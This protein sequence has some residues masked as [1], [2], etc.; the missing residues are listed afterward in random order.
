MRR[1]YRERGVLFG[2]ERSL[3]GVSCR[4]VQSEGERPVI[5]F[6]NSGIVHRIGGNRIYVTLARAL[7]D[8]GFGSL[9]FDLAGIGD[10]VILPTSPSMTPQ[11]RTQIDI[12]DALQFASE[13]LDADRFIMV[14]LCSGADNALRT[15]GR[16]ESVVGS[17]LLDLNA[18]RTPGYYLRHYSRRLLRGETWRNLL[19]GKH[20]LA[21]TLL[22]RVREPLR[23][24]EGLSASP[25]TDTMLPNA[26]LP[27]EMLR[28]HLERIVARDAKVF[29]V[30]TA[31][32]EGQYNYERQ[33]LDMFPDLDFGRSLRLEYFADSDHEF[34]R[35]DLQARLTD[36]VVNWAEKTDF[37]YPG[38]SARR[39]LAVAEG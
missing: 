27:R 38:A 13:R 26:V 18:Y 22:H 5:I 25:S 15:M 1:L 20:P 23:G 36:L 8:R 7:A 9:R 12:D 17:I 24:S 10:S 28:D 30:F 14:G 11:E 37:P 32:L 35:R 4:P 29:A 16:N 31:G 33:F 3:V 34:S 6:L 19:T 2:R 21:Q 39:R